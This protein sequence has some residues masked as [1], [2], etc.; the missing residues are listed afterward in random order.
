MVDYDYGYY[1]DFEAVV[2]SAGTNTQI[3]R[4]PWP[5]NQY[6]RLDS[7]RVTN[8]IGSGS[9]ILLWDQDLSNTT[10]TTRGSAGQALYVLTVG[11]ASFSGQQGTTVTEQGLD[12]KFYGGIACQGATVNMNIAVRAQICR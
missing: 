10:P 6:I 12:I 2:V 1:D 4:A 7:I 5:K 8:T 9:Q 11:G 3:M